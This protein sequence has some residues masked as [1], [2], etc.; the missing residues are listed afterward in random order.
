M[1]IYSCD[2]GHSSCNECKTRGRACGLCGRTITDRRN[3][4][5]E[6]LIAKTKAPCP[7]AN[8][9]CK[10][11]IEIA[12]MENHI[13]ECPFKE[14]NC[15]LT[16]IFGTCH[17]KGKLSQLSNHFDNAH[18]SG[19]Q[20]NVDTEIKLT[21]V[22]NN[23]QA[24]YL[25][26]LGVYNFLVHEKV[27]QTDGKVY[28]AIQLI[29]TKFSAMKWV[30]EIHVY[31]KSENRRKYTYTDNCCSSNDKI[32]DVFEAGECAVLPVWHANTFVC[33]GA[34]TYKF[35]IKK[36]NEDN[37]GFHKNNRGRGKNQK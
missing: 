15:P 14:Q 13:K 27:S 6:N 25:V 22:S 28:M 21:N 3:F 16:A 23:S 34:L 30:Y 12:N 18:P 8:E 19:R 9:G 4:D 5:I 17:W 32:D 35:F 11:F 1:R 26:C 29:G 20:I 24:V 10:L 33:D 2:E 37:K 31:N 7:H 36:T